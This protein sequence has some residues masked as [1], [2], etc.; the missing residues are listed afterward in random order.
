MNSFQLMPS[1][2]WNASLTLDKNSIRI[3]MTRR[4]PPLDLHYEKSRKMKRQ[5]K[6]LP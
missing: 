5:K 3:K 2:N 1:P 4:S 6:G